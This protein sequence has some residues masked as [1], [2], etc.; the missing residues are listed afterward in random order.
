MFVLSKTPIKS[1]YLANLGQSCK[2]GR[3]EVE[4]I[5]CKRETRSG[6]WATGFKFHTSQIGGLK[7]QGPKNR[8]TGL[9]PTLYSFDHGKTWVF[10]SRLA[11][12]RSLGRKLV[13]SRETRKE[14]SYDAIQRINR[15]YGY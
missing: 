4:V 12:L 14:F 8:R 9:R 1:E 7:R 11:L 3:Y 15:Q 10:N 5:Q 6:T 13:L 2:L